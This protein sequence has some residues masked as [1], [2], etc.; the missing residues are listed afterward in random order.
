MTIQFLLGLIVGIAAGVAALNWFLKRP[1]AEREA[2]EEKMQAFQ[3][4]ISRELREEMDR[5][6]ETLERSRETLGE[7]FERTSKMMNEQVQS[8]TERITQMKA[9]L[10][11]MGEHV[12][13]V[14]SF[15]E[16]FRSPK[17]R[18]QW[19]E[20]S[21]ANILSQHYPEDLFR[22]QYMFKNGE[23]VDAALKLP[24]NLLLPIDAKFPSEN[25]SKMVEAESDASKIEF[26]KNFI[27]DV[28]TRIDEIAQKYI[29]PAE[30]T[31]DFALMY[32]PAEAIYYEI[33]NQIAKE[34]DLVGYAW[35]KKVIMTSPNTLYLTLRTIEHWY[36]DVQI[37]RETRAILGR[38]AKVLQDA[39]KLS[40]DFGKLG[41]HLENARSAYD[42][43]E[44]R[45]SIMVEGVE[46][47]TA[48]KELKKLETGEEL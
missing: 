14:A 40:D 25:F 39:K 18:G 32:V 46:K 17:L 4:R 42:S 13:D 47:L 31:T 35:Q 15:Q 29:L 16:L 21:L 41:R 3:D 27:Q 30:G 2:L 33:I 12:K 19:G 48:S 43:S 34:I 38:L 7:R 45:L 6:R 23:R 24:N 20:A 11:K 9:E 10:D 1:K 5:M 22:L 36:K 26:R 8:F 37:S 28:K 44:K